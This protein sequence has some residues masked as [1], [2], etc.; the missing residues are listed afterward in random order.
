MRDHVPLFRV[1]E[2]QL[3][4]VPKQ[5]I[6]LTMHNISEKPLAIVGLA[7]RLPGA[8]NIEEYWDMLV[9]GKSQLGELPP[10]RLDPE[11]NYSPRKDDPTRSYTKLGGIVPELPTNLQK[12]KNLVDTLERFHKLHLTLTE[13]AYDACVNA[14]YDP[15][16]MPVG[17]AGV[18]IGHTPPGQ[19]IGK[20][21]HAYNIV[22]STELLKDSEALAAAVPGQQDEVVNELVDIIR[23]EFP[24]GHPAFK[25]CANAYHAAGAIS[26]NFNL[27]GPAMSFDAACASGMRAFAAAGRALQLGEIGFALVGSASYSYSDTLTLFSQAQSVSPTGTRPYDN[28]ADGLVASEGYVIFAMKTLEQAIAD[29]DDIKA[30]VRGVGVS[31]DGKGKSLWA[32]RKEGQIEAIKRAYTENLSPTQLQFLEMHA[33]STQVGDA[34]EMEAIT[35]VLKDQLPAG[36]KIPVG[37]VKANVGHT[38]ET[39]GMASIAK[40]ILA[41]N[42]QMIPPQINITELNKNIPWDEIPFFVPLQTYS[43]PEPAP[44]KPRLAA[45]NAFG[46]GGLNVHVVLEGYHPEYSK[47]LVENQPKVELPADEEAIAIVGR[48]AILPGALTIDA[49]WDQLSSGQDC[50]TEAPASRWNK[51][52]GCAH[53]PT[54]DPWTVPMTTGAYITDFEY[55]WKKHKVPPKQI[56]SADPLQ[57]MLLDATDQALREI[58]YPE[59]PLDKMRTGAIVGTIFGGAFTNEL[60]HG[61][62]LTRNR[63]LIGEILRKKGVP[64]EQI[65]AVAEEFQQKILKRFPALIDE[66][67]SFTASTLSSR[68]TKT[69]DLMGGAV[70]IDGGESSSITALATSVDILRSGDCDVMIC[71]SGQR[72]CDFAS[73]QMLKVN[74][75]LSQSESVAGP[76]EEDADGVIPGESVGVLILKRL[77]DAKRDGDTIHGIIRGIGCARQDKL[78]D[79]MQAAMERALEDAG[80]SAD[81]VSLVETASGGVPEE[82]RAEIDALKK[83]YGSDDRRA[84]LYLGSAAAMY[85]HSRGGSGMTSLLKSMFELSNTTIP[86]TPHMERAAGYLAEVQ[87]TL[88]P[89]SRKTALVG[90]NEN[91]KVYAGIDSFAESGVCYHLIVEGPT[92]L[93]CEPV[94]S[95]SDVQSAPAVAAIPE[96]SGTGESLSYGEFY[97][98]RVSAVDGDSLNRKVATLEQTDW[99]NSQFTPG[100]SCRLTIVARDDEEFQKKLDMLKKSFT[101][102]SAFRMLAERG[103]FPHQIKHKPKVAYCFP[104]Q[105]SQYKGM[106]KD[107]IEYSPV[108]AKALETVN[109]ALAAHDL[110]SFAELSWE[111]ECRLDSVSQVQLS[112]IAADYIMWHAVQEMGAEADRVCGHS[113]GELAALVAAGSWDIDQAIVATKARV[114]AINGTGEAAGVLYSTTAP[115]AVAQNCCADVQGQVFVSHANSPEQTVIGGADA[116]AAEAAKLIEAAGY[117]A[118][119]LNVPGAFHT[120]LLENVREPFFTTLDKAHLEPPRTPLLSSVTNKYVSD[121][122]DIRDNLKIQMVTPINY[123]DLIER[124]ISEDAD[125]LIEVG[126]GHVLT[127]LNKRIV[128]KRDIVFVGA[129]HAKRNGLEQL[130]ILRACFEAYGCLDWNDDLISGDAVGGITAIAEESGSGEKKQHHG[131]SLFSEESLVPLIHLSGTPFEMGYQQGQQLKG[132]IRQLLRRYTNLAGTRWS[133]LF[134]VGGLVEQA[135]RL[136]TPAAL[137]EVQG[138]ASGAEVSYNGLLA[139]N[140][141]LFLDAGQGGL[142][143]AV[144]AHANPDTGLLH[145]ANEDVRNAL[146]LNDCLQ[147][148]VQVRK[149]ASGNSYLTFTVPGQVGCLT[150]INAAGLAISMTCLVDMDGSGNPDGQLQ[151]MLVQNLLANASDIDSA[152]DILKNHNTRGA[153][154]LCMSHAATDRVCYIEFDGANYQIRPALSALIATNHQQLNEAASSNLGCSEVKASHH[155]YNRLR[156]L[157]GDAGRIPV[158]TERFGEALRDEH[159]PE[160]KGDQNHPTLNSVKRSDNHISV[161]MQPAAGKVWVTPGPNANGHR[162]NFSL[163]DLATTLPE[164]QPIEGVAAPSSSPSGSL[165]QNTIVQQEMWAPAAKTDDAPAVANNASVEVSVAQLQSA[166]NHAMAEAPNQVCHRQLVRMLERR[167]VPVAFPQFHGPA[168]IYGDNADALALKAY[169]EANGVGVMLL[170]SR[171]PVEDCLNA[172]D[173]QWHVAPAPHLFIMTGRD[174]DAVTTLEQNNWDDRREVGVVAAYRIAQKWFDAAFKAKMLNECTLAAATAMGGD[175]GLTGQLKNVEGGA[176]TGL[177]KA[178]QMESHMQ[179]QTPGFLSCVVDTE[180]TTDANQLAQ[181]LCSELAA[182]HQDVEVAYQGGRRYVLRPYAE[183]V[184]SE[185]TISLPAG[186][187]IVVTGG[188]RGVTAVV[189]REMGKRFPGVKLHLIGSS[190]LPNL[191]DSYYNMSEEEMKDVKASVMKEALANGEKPMDA[192]GRFEKALEIGRT[193][194]EFAAEGVEAYYNGCD[195]SNL[196]ALANVLNSIRSEYGAISGVIHGAG[197]EKA[198]RFDKKQEELVRRTI[199]AKVDGAANLLALTAQDPVQF[200][201]AF[202]SVSG[203]FGGVGQT[204]YSVA[205]DMVA[206]LMDW[207]R[208][209]R[210]DLPTAVFHWHAWDDVGM[211]VR[212][213]SQHIRKLHNINF[214]PSLEGAK[215]LL[216]EI[217]QGLPQNE[218]IITEINSFKS[219]I[220]E[221]AEEAAPEPAENNQSESATV[222]SS[223]LPPM[224]DRIISHTPGQEIVVESELDPTADVFLTQHQF[225]QRPMFP[226]VV[227]ME[228][229]A[230]AAQLLAGPE[231][232]VIGLRDLKIINSIRFPSDNPIL[233]RVIATQQADGIHVQLGID[234]Y[235]RRGVLLQQNR[236]CF[237]C[238]VE[239]AHQPQSIERPEPPVT[240]ELF[241]CTYPNLEEAIIYHGPIFRS[242]KEM[243]SVED[244]G[245]AYFEAPPV[246]DVAGRRARAGWIMPSS[247]LDGCFFGCGAYL[248]VVRSGVI[249]IPNGVRRI[250][251]GGLPQE[252]ERCTSTVRFVG[253]D[254]HHGQFDVVLYDSQNR[255]ILEVEGYENHIVPGANQPVSVESKLSK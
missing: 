28:N 29:G 81:Q 182:R 14:G 184:G 39:A 43:W 96:S 4:E 202:G 53:G 165:I 31:S 38:L 88:S 68:L 11:L 168:I 5:E 204:D 45:V 153:W 231:L 174:V 60:Q 158:S 215:H 86:D 223:G 217:A 144:T 101:S 63:K 229:M 41:M 156:E 159:D 91:G 22:H 143:A 72:A 85:G 135:H 93:P 233:L 44:G 220:E 115:V 157:L 149:P 78:V 8:D 51:E 243:G 161:I 132:E 104:G 106:L 200:F 197:F 3:I 128:G 90:I 232:R 66:T 210:P 109:S 17:R 140:I 112:V 75:L 199:G 97:I 55:D 234:Y 148:V 32:P 18:Y 9:N 160:N 146:P 114:D 119:K 34:T 255:V 10:D 52:V 95:V 189:A 249:A 166:C 79:G 122:A 170:P 13:V 254:D 117:K 74:K 178:V 172:I 251:L 105:G 207:S 253:Q 186:S 2:T 56:Q 235:N 205:N 180:S 70:A 225:K 227:A 239:V 209:H 152:I 107:V 36:Y 142:T 120:P 71:A 194:R 116:A 219:R 102:S 103:I 27:D 62:S 214:M 84:P 124:F 21:I 134:D 242:L 250:S 76:F 208:T 171:L 198:T 1:S 155:R 237:T 126:P 138:M 26:S 241:P 211:A 127:G 123:T 6:D 19:T 150:G 58:G 206:K 57:F 110:P 130:A 23:S 7:C 92:K 193:L 83:V 131:D 136:F 236:P 162:D 49:L 99:R 33:T 192:W 252:G 24:E 47:A 108:A 94:K 141:R 187:N 218:V 224:V 195:I 133:H 100:E 176:I 183:F 221:D 80:I 54:N 145:A 147:R 167:A 188:A 175:F 212:P 185:Q 137:E 190:P 181:W 89:V 125:L 201:V 25:V 177:L 73:Y 77:A 98:A 240:T 113:L 173:A 48:G 37:S 46:I 226:F 238:V 20:L 87:N 228:S 40:T 30:V 64:E 121:P 163:I 118:I 35:D 247:L 203:R 151:T 12:C 230:E 222:N 42:H 244:L 69:F 50:F 245:I 61:L 196:E 82:S 67:G 59:K 111:D 139:H 216:D 164:W 248:W 213:E 129:N 65:T 191:A 169:L 16:N 15:L 246:T 179:H 154:T